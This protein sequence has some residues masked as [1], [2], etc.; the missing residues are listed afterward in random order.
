MFLFTRTNDQIIF[1]TSY[2]GLQATFWLFVFYLR[3]WFK[4]NNHWFIYLIILGFSF[5][6][7]WLGIFSGD[8]LNREFGQVLI[9]LKSLFIVSLIAFLF[10]QY[11]IENKKIK[12]T[13]SKVDV[14]GL[15]F[16]AIASVSFIMSSYPILSKASNLRNFIMPILVFFAGR[17][18]VVNSYLQFNKIL[19]FIVTFGVF[20][21]IIGLIEFLILD[22]KTLFFISNSSKVFLAKIGQEV[23]IPNIYTQFGALLFRRLVSI[24]YEPLTA[25]FYFSAAFIISI[26]LKRNFAATI[27][28]FALAFTFHKAGWVIAAFTLS[29][30]L[31]SRIKPEWVKK[32]LFIVLTL[33]FCFSIWVSLVLV[34][35]SV[36]SHWLG[37]VGGI[38]SGFSK[39]FGHGIG[40]GGYF[41]WM[42]GAIA[43]DVNRYSFGVDSGVGSI[44]YQLGIVGVFCYFGWIILIFKKLSKLLVVKNPI[45]DN[46]HFIS[47]ILVVKGLLLSYMIVVIFTENA[48]SLYSNYLIFLLSGILI[49]IHAHKG[50]NIEFYGPP[51]NPN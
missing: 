30:F 23:D 31:I 15:L 21:A 50:T 32:P 24:F 2:I 36:L 38:Q 13:I 18:L 29:Y 25:G 41:S 4:H 3:N 10:I 26:L 45:Q 22:I 16:I 44:S 12:L 33:G 46:A 34:Q 37:L 14:F 20:A 11:V 6:N 27:L 7:I 8:A 42:Y 9:V 48:L 17:M 35:T 43:Q 49:S 51:V 39:P 40:S 47:S 28:F 19:N 5:Q 1:Y